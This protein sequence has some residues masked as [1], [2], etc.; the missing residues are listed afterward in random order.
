MEEI[1]KEAKDEAKGI[2]DEAKKIAVSIKK[3]SE[4][5]AKQEATWIVEEAKVEATK[6]KQKA[7]LD[8]ENERKTLYAELKW[9]V[10]DVALKINEKMFTKSDANKDFIKKTL[11]SEKL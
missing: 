5:I 8:I 10:L 11:E 3:D 6:I 7:N 2:L 9:K 4:I 1:K